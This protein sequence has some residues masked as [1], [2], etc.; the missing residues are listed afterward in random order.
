VSRYI[1]QLLQ[2]PVPR[3]WAFP[4][5]EYQDR[6]RRVKKA[7][8]QRGIDVLL[9][10]S[11]VDMCYLVGYQTLWPD[12]YTCL[13]VPATGEAFMQIAEMEASCAILHG[14]MRDFV[15]YI[16]M[17]AGGTAEQLAETLQAR[18]LADKRIGVQK[19]R[20]EIG[21]RGPVDA[22]SYEILRRRLPDAQLVDATYLMFD[23]R[24]K[25]SRAEIQVMKRA[26]EIT[27]HGIRAAI[28]A[29]AESR[30][31][32]EVVKAGVSAMLDS[33]SEFFSID[34][35]VTT[36]HRSG[37]A[38]TTWKRHRIIQGDHVLLE[39]G[40]VYQRYT[41][42]IMRT[43]VLGKPTREAEKLG[44]AAIETLGLL[45]EN[46]RPGRTGHEVAV[47]A[48]KGLESI[49]G[50]NVFKPGMFGY[51]IGL[52][53]P[54]TWT[55]GPMYLGEGNDR[56]LE[57]G[58]TFHTPISLRIPGRKIVGLSESVLVTEWGCEVLTDVSRELFV[59]GEE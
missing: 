18:G 27:G 52:G 33:G 46:I 5:T 29:V 21:N 38:H 44:Q 10:H 57:E 56:E 51:S 24:V 50:I 8:A 3:E 14:P 54:P 35:V 17:E 47:A 6:M 40:G 53:F 16:W 26:A 25:K 19:G 15:P 34:P 20:L 58:M 2:E 9:V 37:W 41:T 55:D 23:V 42:P 7:M 36:G 4:E 59:R 43:V 13:V 39:F 31:D 49:R 28:G 32:N 30:L 1:E 12:A 45:I 11:V 48:A 22:A